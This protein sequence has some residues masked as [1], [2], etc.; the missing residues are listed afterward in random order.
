MVTP[1]KVVTSSFL[2]KEVG[3][4]ELVISDRY[5]LPGGDTHETLI[6]VLQLTKTVNTSSRL[7]SPASREP[8]SQPS[9][10]SGG[11]PSVGEYRLGRAAWLLTLRGED[12]RSC[13]L[14]H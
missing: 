8:Q 13:A 2:L 3:H 12:L 11:R 7:C 14:S 6:K 5:Q 9:H 4:Y 1:L 10:R